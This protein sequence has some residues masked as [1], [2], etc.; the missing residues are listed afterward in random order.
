MWGNIYKPQLHTF[1]V[2]QKKAIHI[3]AKANY[4]ENTHP[5]FVQYVF[6]IFRYCKIKNL[7][8]I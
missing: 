8:Y 6:E 7:D 4:L 3:I 1:M 2:L 5:L